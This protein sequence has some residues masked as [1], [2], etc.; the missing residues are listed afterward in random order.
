MPFLAYLKNLFKAKKP[1]PI[2]ASV[3]PSLII[4]SQDIKA[5]AGEDIMATQLDLAQAYIELDKKK[6]AKKILDHVV[7]HGNAFQQQEACALIAKIETR[8]ANT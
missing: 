7:E 6:L 8:I 5:I 2:L 3:K 4:T 1:E